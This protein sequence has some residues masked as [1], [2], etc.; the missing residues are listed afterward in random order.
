MS[1]GDL[2]PISA[3]CCWTRYFLQLGV[4]RSD[5][6]YGLGYAIIMGAMGATVHVAVSFD[7]VADDAVSTDQRAWAGVSESTRP[8]IRMYADPASGAPDR[9]PEDNRPSRVLPDPWAGVLSWGPAI[10]ACPEA[11]S[12]PSA[13]APNGSGHRQR[14][15]L[16]L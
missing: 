13:G 16:G 2:V 10:V 12:A 6:V 4:S 14:I 5:T 8:S 1:T 3:D 15:R 9:L 11:A 7:T